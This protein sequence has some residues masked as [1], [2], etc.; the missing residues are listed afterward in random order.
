MRRAGGVENNDR[1]WPVQAQGFKG[2]LARKAAQDEAIK[3]HSER[4][5]ALQQAVASL[6]ARHEAVLRSQFESVKKR[7]AQLCQQL[8]HILRYV[9]SSCCYHHHQYYY[10]CIFD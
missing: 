7:H 6:A 4:L 3:E 10:L 2:L 5:Q 9:S 1:L 8:L